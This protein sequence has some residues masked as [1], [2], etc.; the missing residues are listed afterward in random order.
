M[1]SLYGNFLNQ[2]I[3]YF[4]KKLKNRWLFDKFLFILNSIKLKKSNSKLIAFAIIFPILL[5]FIVSFIYNLKFTA[6]Q[7]SIPYLLIWGGILNPI[8]EEFM[9]RGLIIGG[10]A[11]IAYILSV[12]RI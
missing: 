2:I 9:S 4:N 10:M 8:S 7:E 1:A 6:P 3:S 5:T 12:N 11:L